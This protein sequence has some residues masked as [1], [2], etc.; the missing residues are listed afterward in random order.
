VNTGVRVG[1][2]LPAYAS[3]TGHVLLAGQPD[4]EVDE[5]LSRVHLRARTPKTPTTRTEIAERVERARREG[6]AVTDEELELG[7]RSMAVPVMNSRSDIVAAMSV[8][9]FAARVTV[10]E[11]LQTFLPPLRDNAALLGRMI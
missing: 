5:Y 3:A 4:K 8:S 6:F 9:A 11:L 10:N 1:A 7:L 2:S